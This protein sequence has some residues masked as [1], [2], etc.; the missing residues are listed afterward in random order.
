MSYKGNMINIS[1]Q[2]RVFNA[3][4]SF[5]SRHTFYSALNCW[6]LF[7]TPADFYL[8]GM[9]FTKPVCVIKLPSFC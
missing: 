3:F 2:C 5:F 9:F 7:V 8:Q 1:K 4:L 6:C